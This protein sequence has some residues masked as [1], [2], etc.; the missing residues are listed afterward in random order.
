VS[1]VPGA[2]PG[3]VHVVLPGDIDDPATPSGGNIYDRRVCD[4][5]AALGWS[6][7]EHAVHGGWPRPGPDECAAL[8]TLLA[9]L[10]AGA[11]V[12]LDGLIASAV[13]GVLRPQAPRLRMVVLVH[14][15]L[16][17]GAE[18]DALADAKAIVTTSAWTSRRLIERYGLP[19][20][21][22]YAAEP[23]VDPAAV[24]PG[25]EG[26]TQLLCVAAVAPHKGHDVLIEALSSLAAEPWTCVCVGSLDRDHAFVDELRR[27]IAVHGLADRVRLAGPLVGDALH[28]AY[29]A[30]DLLV[31]ASRGETYGMVVA[32]ALARGIPVVAAATGGLPETLGL[33]PDGSAP[34]LLVPAGD[35][36]ALSDALRGWLGDPGLRQRLRGSARARRATLTGWS[37]TARQVADV[38]ERVS[39]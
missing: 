32:E 3:A 2:V 39:A 37:T 4:A 26:G 16:D 27:R 11:V 20:D 8:G 21:R 24:A 13:P 14:M 10:P 31:L 38:L 22:V 35:S 34:G 25:S 30:A 7:H 33:A 18:R 28:T 23:G 9:A 17:D 6:V 15:P 19:A 1:A 12:L 5:L 36:A 29:A